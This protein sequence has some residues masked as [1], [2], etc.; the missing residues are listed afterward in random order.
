MR[1][2]N[3]VLFFEEVHMDDDI[4]IEIIDDEESYE[5]KAI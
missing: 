2:S 4:Q 1:E 3:S 5:A